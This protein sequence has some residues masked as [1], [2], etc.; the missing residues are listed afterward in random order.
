MLYEVITRVREQVKETVE[1]LGLATKAD[2]EELKALIKK[3]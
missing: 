2:I 3:S 1:S